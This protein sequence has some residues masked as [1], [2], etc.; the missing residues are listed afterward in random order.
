MSDRYIRKRGKVSNFKEHIENKIDTEYHITTGKSTVTS[1]INYKSMFAI[2][3][4]SFF[5]ES[6][7]PL[8]ISNDDELYIMASNGYES[9]NEMLLFKNFTNG[10]NNYGTAKY[11]ALKSILMTF[12]LA[13]VGAVVMYISA[14]KGLLNSFWFYG[15]LFIFGFG[16]LVCFWAFKI[17]TNIKSEI[18]K[19]KN[20]T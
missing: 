14:S 5:Y 2:E 12:L 13:L 1:E 7:K 19:I 9:G 15:A 17:Y 4:A 11:N 20:M 10:T 3:N 6:K 16:S 8:A 18:E